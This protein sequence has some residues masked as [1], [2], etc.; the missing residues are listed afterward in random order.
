[1]SIRTRAVQTAVAALSVLLFGCSDATR[2]LGPDA[3]DEPTT[4]TER[5]G[6]EV[7]HLADGDGSDPVPLAEGAYP[8]WSPDGTRIVFHRTSDERASHRQRARDGELFV[9]DVEGSEATF[10]GHGVQPAWSPDGERVV[11]VSS[12]GIAVMNADGSGAATL[13]P[14][15]FLDHAHP[16]SDLGVGAPDWSPDGERIAFQHMGDGYIL[17]S[18]LYVMDADG[19]DPRRLTPTEGRQFAEAF[20]AWKP[21]GSRI[22]F[23]SYGHGIAVVR[24]AGGRPDGLFE[25]AGVVYR[26]NPTWSPHGIAFTSLVGEEDRDEDAEIWTVEGGPLIS[27]A[28]DAAWSPDGRRVVFV[29][30]RD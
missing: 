22:V 17:P 12:D 5:P 6:V 28:R 4:S 30:V 29:R 25:H 16:A 23:W 19:S 27:D 11:F 13:L 2:P 9:M 7:L 15:D 20:P 21:D 14:H 26:A 8:A 1:M 24:G 18:Q 10:L 3:E